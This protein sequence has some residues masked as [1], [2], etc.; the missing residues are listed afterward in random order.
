[1]TKLAAKMHVNLARK[2]AKYRAKLR[3]FLTEEFETIIS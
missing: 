2:K 3:T 1:M